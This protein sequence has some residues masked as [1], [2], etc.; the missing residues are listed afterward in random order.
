MDWS[1]PVDLYC[2]RTAPGLFNE[3]FNAISNLAFF[4]A[5]ALAVAQRP[6][7]RDVFLVALIALVV[8]IGI[9]STAF[10]MFANRWSLLADTVP[11]AAFIHA[12]F[13]YA[14]L[15]FVA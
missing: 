10:H 7:R 2:E 12:F 14:M 6:A 4:A 1:A 3:P 13:L 8:L 5:A 15:R 9:G 11:I